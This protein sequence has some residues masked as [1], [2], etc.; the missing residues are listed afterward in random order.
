MA[1]WAGVF[2]L[3]WLH[4][5]WW[6][7]KF[8]GWVLVSFSEQLRDNVMLLADGRDGRERSK[9]KS[10]QA[11]KKKKRLSSGGFGVIQP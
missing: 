6:W 8:A 5:L 11:T 7:I 1:F 4:G 2:L 10:K 3:R 9:V